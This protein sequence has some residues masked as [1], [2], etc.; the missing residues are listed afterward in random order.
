MMGA[1]L[2]F[3]IGQNGL[4]IFMKTI[5]IFNVGFMVIQKAFKRD[6]ALIMQR[7]VILIL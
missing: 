7:I 6:M 5:F 2:G 1:K 4:S 3:L